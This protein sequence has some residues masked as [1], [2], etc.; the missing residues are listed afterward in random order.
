MPEPKKI[1]NIEISQDLDFQNRS[2]RVQ[3]TAW[4]V[5]LGVVVAGLL[6]LFGGG[7]LSSATLGDAESGAVV[8]Y[9]RFLRA[10]GEHV[11]EMEIAPSGVD[12]DSI[13]T[14]WMNGDWLA[15]NQLIGITPAPQSE[16]VQPDRILY[17]FRVGA[18]AS[19]VVVRFSLRST[20]PGVHRWRG[21]VE[22]GAALSF[23]QLSYP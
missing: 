2:W 7:P 4:M 21:G 20:T 14:L 12:G 3:R 11:L 1:G 16:V 13:A 5:M 9:E 18:P 6:G 8:R 15:A 19:A 10:G 23:R 22:G 17:R